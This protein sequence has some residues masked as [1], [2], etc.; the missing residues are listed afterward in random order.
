MGK[1]DGRCGRARREA[2]AVKLQPSRSVLS[3]LKRCKA[4]KLDRSACSDG[5]SSSPFGGR[6]KPIQ[7]GRL[8]IK[9]ERRVRLEDQVNQSMQTS[10]TAVLP[11]IDITVVDD[12]VRP[13]PS[14]RLFGY[15]TRT[16]A[17]MWGLA[18]CRYPVRRGSR[19][20]PVVTA[21]QRRSDVVSS[22]GRRW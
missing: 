11:T 21:L 18:P 8:R 5:R 14:G 3:F 2:T 13:W 22:T 9:S 4:M 7:S 15:R 6:A 17:H 10:R 12:C 19:F 16:N 1:D 20:Q